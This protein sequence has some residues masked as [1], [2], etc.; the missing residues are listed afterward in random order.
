MRSSAM[1]SATSTDGSTLA[2]QVALLVSRGAKWTNRAAFNAQGR[3]TL[4]TSRSIDGR[5]TVPAGFDPTKVA[6]RVRTL[7][8]LTGPGEF[9]FESFP[10]EDHFPGLDTG[11]AGILRAPSG[12]RRSISFW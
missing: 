5:V 6:V 9:D 4:Q 10:R 3:V 2:F 8:I 7:N 1:N 12:R 11:I